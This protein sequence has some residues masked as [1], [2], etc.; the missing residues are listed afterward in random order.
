MKKKFIALTG[1]FVLMIFVLAGCGDQTQ[2][3]EQNQIQN[4]NSQ[5]INQRE[6][7]S[8]SVKGTFKE[9][10]GQGKR[11]KCE[12]SFENTETKMH[13]VAYTDGQRMYQEVFVDQGDLDEDIKTS[14]ITKN[15]QVYMWN[16]MQPEQGMK[17]SLNEVKS[18]PEM[19]EETNESL[20]SPGLSQSFDYKCEPWQVND[21]KFEIPSDKNFMD[22]NSFM[23]GQ[24]GGAQ[25]DNNNPE[26][27]TT[28]NS[29]N[30]NQQACDACQYAP[31]PDECLEEMG[32]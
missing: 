20:E 24:Q 28:P 31:N 14:L 6:N 18:D 12:F 2:Q 3:Q 5:Q 29:M 16:S 11:L 27:S 25:N 21:E 26:K 13:G 8:N 4:E 22:M 9:L 30:M 17:I 19:T 32:C 1:L 15:N 7:E 10:L 23:R